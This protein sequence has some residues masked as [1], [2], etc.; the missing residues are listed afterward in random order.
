MGVGWLLRCHVVQASEKLENTRV[1]VVVGVCRLPA[2]CSPS[3]EVSIDIV[4]QC[5]LQS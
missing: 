5:E 3:R 2:T 1:G 4:L